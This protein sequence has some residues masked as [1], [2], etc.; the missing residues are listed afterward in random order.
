MDKSNIDYGPLTIDF[1]D[2]E[3][4]EVNLID[5]AQYASMNDDPRIKAFGRALKELAP[6]WIRFIGGEMDRDEECGPG[7]AVIGLTKTFAMLAGLTIVPATS[8]PS[9]VEPLSQGMASL[10]NRDVT[11]LTEYLAKRGASNAEKHKSSASL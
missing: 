9:N 7:N 6:S 2:L 11:L 1:T 5:F 10:F 8:N 4:V 3:S